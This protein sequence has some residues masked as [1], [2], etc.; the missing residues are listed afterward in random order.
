MLYQDTPD[1]ILQKQ[2]EILMQKP[3]HKRL[4]MTLQMAEDSRQMALMIIKRENPMLSKSEQNAVF[5]QRIYKDYFSETELIKIINH[6][7]SQ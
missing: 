5:F 1:F 7:K 4:D 2:R 3:P 6:L